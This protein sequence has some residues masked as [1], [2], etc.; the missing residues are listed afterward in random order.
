MEAGMAMRAIWRGYL[1]L[2]LV[3]CAVALYPA[4]TESN[5]I[6]F[7]KINRE[8]GH[9][10][11]MRM[12]DE[13]TGEEVP[14]EQQ[15]RGYEVETGETVIVEPSDI[16][17]IR[18][19]ST[20]VLEIDEF[21]P[22]DE[23]DPLYIGRPYYL[24][25][26]DE[27][28]Q[29]A[30][31]VIREAMQQR[32]IGAISKLV[33]NDRERMVLLEPRGVGIVATLLRWPYEMRSEDQV[34]GAIPLNRTVPQELIDMAGEVVDRRMAHFNPSEFEDRYEEALSDL[35]RAKQAGQRPAPMPALSTTPA[36][37]IFEALKASVRELE[38]AMPNE[39]RARPVAGSGRPT[40][41]TASA[42]RKTARR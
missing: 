32:S 20:H 16:D 23:I 11:R 26:E 37:S 34:F 27:A 30:F 38:R 42:G 31:I 4:T 18:L 2:S 1:R 19:Q 6:N 36:S 22:R 15:A 33:M 5:R 39:R 10:L 41:R 35:I 40:T 24:A 25:P 8:T 12:I 13:E 28:S 9:R 3:N 7:H 14:S 21:V 17:D 29:E